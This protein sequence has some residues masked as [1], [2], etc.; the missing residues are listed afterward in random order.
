LNLRPLGPEPAVGFPD[1]VASER[2]GSDTLDISEGTAVPYPPR[3]TP[4]EAEHARDRAA[5]GRVLLPE[6]LLSVR[7]VAA[8]LGGCRATVYSMVERGELRCVRV[9][10]VVRFNPSDLAAF[11]GTQTS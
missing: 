3:A 10:N 9:S 5:V 7:E 4:Y 2:K 1:G 6:K 8:R 11:I